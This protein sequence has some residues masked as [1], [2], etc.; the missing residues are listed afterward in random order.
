Q[1]S[2]LETDILMLNCITEKGA[3]FC[4]YIE[5]YSLLQEIGLENLIRVGVSENTLLSLYSKKAYHDN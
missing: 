1:I 4:K 5:R 2:S 3:S